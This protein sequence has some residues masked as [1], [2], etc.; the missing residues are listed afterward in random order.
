MVNFN[1]DLVPADAH[2]LN[3]RNR[4]LL[5]GDALTET[6]RHTGEAILFW[7][8]HYFRLMASMRQLRMEIPMTFTL[9]FLEAEVSK[10]LTAGGL[11]G[12]PALAEIIVFRK[13]GTDLLP[14]SLES[15]FI[16]RATE[17]STSGFTPVE[18]PVR[19]DLFR[20]YYIQADGLARL[21]HNNRIVQV[22]AG[23]YARENDLETCLLLNHRKEIAEGLHGTLFLRTGSAL[24]TPPLHSGCT[25]SVLR[26]HLLK[27]SW[28]ESPFELTEGEISPFELQQADELFLLHIKHGVMPITQYRKAA[29]SSE[30]AHF[31]ADLLNS[32]ISE[33][34]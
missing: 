3:H 34:I 17:L 33:R 14:N 29:Y 4:G 18:G 30:A 6:L 28:Q 27:Q 9:E 13:D 1:G 7:E 15:S 10:T 20:D 2:F 11:A 8:E 32:R 26:D 12:K 5:F 31:T 16:I 24:K 21:A 22:L 23:I 25:G 19:A